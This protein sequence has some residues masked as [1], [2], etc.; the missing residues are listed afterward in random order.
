MKPTSRLMH[1][2]AAA[3]LFCVAAGQA[4]AQGWSPSQPVRIVVPYAAGS[5]ADAVTRRISDQLAASLGQPV[6]IDNRPG[7]NGIIGTD[8]AAKAKPDG[9][10][11]LYGANAPLTINPA[12]YSKLPYQPERDLVPVTLSARGYPL[13]VVHPQLPAKT[14]PELIA[15][16]KARPGKLTYGSSGVGSL[17][18]L[19]MESLEQKTGAFLVHIPYKSS[20]DAMSDLIAG[21]IDL[22]LE[23]GSV[24]LPHVQ[25]GKIRALA[26]VGGEH[27]KPVLPEVPTAAELGMPW[28]EATGWAAYMVPAGTPPEVIERLNRDFTAAL[29]ST[30]FK[31]WVA[32]FGSESHAGTP[33]EAAA[34]IAAETDRWAKIIKASGVRAD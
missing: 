14:L 1:A 21:R 17:T 8:L 2:A 28:F 34:Y 11:L 18:H 10:T 25:A 3:L 15:Y 27:R 7:A 32:R 26:V 33:A 24:A 4:N 5:V 20:G 29:R 23:F 9:Y 19:A 6:V 12:L 31:E 30:E 22:L 13:L 16:A